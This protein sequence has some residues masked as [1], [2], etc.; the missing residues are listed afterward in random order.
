MTVHTGEC[1]SKKVCLLQNATFLLSTQMLHPFLC[2]E[3]R[4]VPPKGH[5]DSEMGAPPPPSACP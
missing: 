4:R 2:L 3:P 5:K 1:V